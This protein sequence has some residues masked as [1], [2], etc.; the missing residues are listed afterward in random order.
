M[1]LEVPYVRIPHIV[2]K[3]LMTRMVRVKTSCIPRALGRRE[4]YHCH[5]LDFGSEGSI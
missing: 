3:V 4:R 5:V 2:T 1:P